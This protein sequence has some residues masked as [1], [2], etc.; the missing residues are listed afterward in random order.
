M[1]TPLGRL[2]TSLCS[3]TAWRV[4]SVDNEEASTLKFPA[5]RAVAAH[6]V[7]Q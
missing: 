6:P 4:S 7:Q 3:A 5:Y 2:P 1:I